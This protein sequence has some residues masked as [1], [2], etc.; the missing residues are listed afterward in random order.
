MSEYAKERWVVFPSADENEKP[1]FDIS[2][3]LGG[4]NFEYLGE[5]YDESVA[6]KIAAAPELYEA[7]KDLYVNCEAPGKFLD[8]AGQAINKADGKP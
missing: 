8:A 4:G 1:C 3:D 5:V 6:N 7:L 2:L